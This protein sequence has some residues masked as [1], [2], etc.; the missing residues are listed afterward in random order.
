[1]RR[2]NLDGVYDTQMNMM[3]YPQIMQPTHARWEQIPSAGTMSEQKPLCKGLANGHSLTN[4]SIE[5]DDHEDA[6]EIEE[7]P[8]SLDVPQPTIFSDVPPVISRNFTVVDTHYTA[9]PISNAGY[10][11]P[12]GHILDS[13]SGPNGI[14]GIP[15]DLVDELPEECRRAFEEAKRTE[16]QWKQQWGTE[17][18]SGLRGH[19]KIGLTGYPV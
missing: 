16:L 14:S 10:P 19:M 8:R 9:P 4:G 15:D 7:I 11:G 6:M 12:D 2:A 13:S 3:Y 1:M 17:A 5:H 18:H